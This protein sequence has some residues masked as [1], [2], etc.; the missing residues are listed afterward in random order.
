M[1]EPM[2]AGGR[3]LGPGC[4][5]CLLLQ[6][7]DLLELINQKLGVI[8]SACWTGKSPNSI[9]LHDGCALT[10]HRP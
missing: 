5:A 6:H 4:P 7:R 3:L 1:W 8:I 2:P 10:L 9:P